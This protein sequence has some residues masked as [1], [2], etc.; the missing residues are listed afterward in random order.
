MPVANNAELM[1]RVQAHA[2]A[3]RMLLDEVGKSVARQWMDANCDEELQA[4]A[5][6]G[7][8]WEGLARDS[9]QTGFMYLARAVQQPAS[10]I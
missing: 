7:M 3:T 8:R 6:E 10:F 9:I 2:E 5:T 1:V 4:L